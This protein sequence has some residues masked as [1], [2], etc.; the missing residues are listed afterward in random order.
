MAQLK[1][2]ANGNYEPKWTVP[3]AAEKET[4]T[5]PA[6]NEKEERVVEKPIITKEQI[7]QL[8]SEPSRRLPPRPKDAAKESEESA[9][10]S[11][12]SRAGA[13]E[14]TTP[15]TAKKAS[16][17]ETKS[18]EDA[19]SEESH[20]FQTPAAPSNADDAQVPERA[21]REDGEQIVARNRT[22]RH[23]DGKWIYAY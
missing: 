2:D 19:S 11:F 21:E 6:V 18:K 8:A 10:T 14:S 15:S 13:V 3:A 22:E 9:L 4:K 12:P 7:G 20:A 17:A 5:S 16:G 23:A 1:K